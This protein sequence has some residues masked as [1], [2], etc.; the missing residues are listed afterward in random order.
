ML[1]EGA[2]VAIGGEIKFERLRLE[3]AFA[4]LVLDR[5]LRKIGLAGDGTE[6][7]EVSRF[8]TNP[9]GAPGRILEGLEDIGTGRCGNASFA[10][11]EEPEAFLPF[12]RRRFVSPDA[13]AS[14]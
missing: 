13:E 5:D 2:F 3:A 8:E 9:V 14:G 10:A 4:G 6:R 7:S 11:A 12:S 1:V